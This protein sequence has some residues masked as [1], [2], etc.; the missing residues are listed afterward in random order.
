MEDNKA[1]ET[2][3][4]SDI[5]EKKIHIFSVVSGELFTVLESEVKNLD[6]HQVP[7]L[8]PPRSSCKHCYGRGYKGKDINTKMYVICNCIIN[9]IDFERYNKDEVVAEIPKIQE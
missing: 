3:S 1:P 6:D 7:L 4:Q 9:H 8:K 5:P 2:Y